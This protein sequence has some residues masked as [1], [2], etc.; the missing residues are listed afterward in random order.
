MII[1]IT[2]QPA[3]GKST[4]ANELKNKLAPKSCLVIDGD[5]FRSETNNQDYS[6][7]G[8]RLNVER[9]MMRALEENNKYNYV[10]VAAVS[11]FIDQRNWIKQKTN[12]KEI[13]LTSTR[14]KEGYMV[15]YYLAP[16]ENYLHIDTDNISI[17]ETTS[18]AL[19]YILS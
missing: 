7:A 3:T 18:K 6:K 9:I 14:V 10:I 2:G 16:L 13:C 19:K 1:W 12:V 17:D 4:L 11:P 8:R 15:D 5:Q